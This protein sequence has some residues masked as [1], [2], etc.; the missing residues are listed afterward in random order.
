MQYSDV[1]YL[2]QIQYG[3]PDLP[4]VVVQSAATNQRLMTLTVVRCNDGCEEIPINEKFI[5]VVQITF[6]SAVSPSAHISCVLALDE[7]IV[8]TRYKMFNS[9]GLSSVN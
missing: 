5:L 7:F 3:L 1:D 6:C 9:S 4:V 8:V 2:S